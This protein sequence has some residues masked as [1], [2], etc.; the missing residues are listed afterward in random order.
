MEE[1]GE[2]QLLFSWE[3][4]EY[5]EGEI[6]AKKKSPPNGRKKKETTHEETIQEVNRQVV[7][8][9]DL[10]IYSL[11]T[12]LSKLTDLKLKVADRVARGSLLSDIKDSNEALLAN[13]AGIEGWINTLEE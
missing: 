1:M 11:S 4:Y 8:G 10:C 7:A 5:T 13:I 12:L 2:D 9:V 3:E 6:M